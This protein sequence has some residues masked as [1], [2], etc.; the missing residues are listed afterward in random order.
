MNTKTEP[1]SDEAEQRILH[2]SLF[3]APLPGLAELG[4]KLS[5][6]DRERLNRYGI[7][8]DA[9]AKGRIR[10]ISQD[11]EHFIEVANGAASPV[12]EFEYLWLRWRS[13]V[14]NRSDLLS[15]DPI[16]LARNHRDLAAYDVGGRGP[17]EVYRP[18]VNRP[19][20]E[21]CESCGGVLP[22]CRC[23]Q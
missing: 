9:L 5:E 22:M 4:W 15:F 10:A 3:R 1:D 8:M 14:A 11:Q 2:K 12:T 7:W 18:Q 19:R 6:K 13:L 17:L 16:E 21:L 20:F 23:T